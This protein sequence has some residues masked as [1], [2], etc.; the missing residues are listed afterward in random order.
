MLEFR[1]NQLLLKKESETP[2]I[3]R[4]RMLSRLSSF[5]DPLGLTSLFILRGRKILKDIFQ[6]G[7]GW[8]ETVMGNEHT[9]KT[10]SLD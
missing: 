9:G 5:C 8:D 2:E 3:T 6:E 4:R 7:P 10:I 1:T